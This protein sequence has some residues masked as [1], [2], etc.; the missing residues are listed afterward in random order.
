[1]VGAE[2]R[3]RTGTRQAP[4]REKKKM[5]DISMGQRIFHDEIGPKSQ[6]VRRDDPDLLKSIPI[7][8]E[9]PC[10]PEEREAL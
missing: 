2:L 10:L 3:S 7:L 8:G 6:G 1:V 5:E 4:E 9:T